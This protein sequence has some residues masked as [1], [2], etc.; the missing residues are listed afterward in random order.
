M[1]RNIDD[2]HLLLDDTDE[3]LDQSNDEQ[4]HRKINQQYSMR[5]NNK[6][7][8]DNSSSSKKQQA[9]GSSCQV[10]QSLIQNQTMI[11]GSSGGNQFNQQNSSQNVNQTTLTALN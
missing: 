10:S 5:S 2:E 1:P 11:S 7:D 3:F 4:C 9:T 6:S 8:I